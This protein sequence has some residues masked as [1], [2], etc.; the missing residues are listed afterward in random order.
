MASRDF[1]CLNCELRMKCLCIY[2]IL[3]LKTHKMH[4]YYKM[5]LDLC[6]LQLNSGV[7]R[8]VGLTHSD[9]STVAPSRSRAEKEAILLHQCNSY[10]TICLLFSE[11]VSFYSLRILSR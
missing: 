2:D 10:F 6:K 9:C 5:P 8:Q 11:Y 3:A 4:E 1:Q 7:R